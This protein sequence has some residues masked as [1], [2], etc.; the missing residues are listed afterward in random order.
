MWEELK[1]DSRRN[2][3]KTERNYGERRYVLRQEKKGI[4]VREESN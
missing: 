1:I 3:S 4:K 2:E